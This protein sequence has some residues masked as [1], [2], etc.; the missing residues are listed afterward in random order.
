MKDRILKAIQEFRDDHGDGELGEVSKE[1]GGY[2]GP[3]EKDGLL[4]YTAE[5]YGGGEGDGEE[6]W[7]V[8]S[9]TDMATNENTF[10]EIPGWYQ[11]YH[12]S[13]LE[14]EDMFQVVPAEKTVTYWKK[15]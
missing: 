8:L 12:G 4:I 6:H 15:A 11:S 1:K 9:V 5:N 10:W 2:R 14:V 7:I 13:E 3:I